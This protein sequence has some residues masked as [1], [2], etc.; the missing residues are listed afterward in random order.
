MTARRN[1]GT[2]A[3]LTGTLDEA[4]DVVVTLPKLAATGTYQVQARYQGSAGVAPSTVNLT[5]TV[6]S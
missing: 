3:S 4:G 1:H 5:L 6:R 2:G